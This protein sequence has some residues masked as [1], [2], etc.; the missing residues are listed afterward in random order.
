MRT[1]TRFATCLGIIATPLLFV[2]FAYAAVGD[3]NLIIAQ[4]VPGAPVGG[5]TGNA[6]DGGVGDI[7]AGSDRT[8]SYDVPSSPNMDD[9][10]RR[11]EPRYNANDPNNGA[12]GYDSNQSG[13]NPR[14]NP[15]VGNGM[16]PSGSNTY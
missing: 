9:Q 13:E 4:G 3:D 10:T 5:T 14:R 15:S 6:G 7:D 16:P 11:H 1:L 8:Q 12:S 2:P